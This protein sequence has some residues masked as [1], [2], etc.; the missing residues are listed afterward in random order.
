MTHNRYHV[1]EVA[2]EIVRATHSSYYYN[3]NGHIKAKEVIRKICQKY[4][5]PWDVVSKD[6]TTLLHTFAMYDCMPAI[7]A[8]VNMGADITTADN[9]GDT[10][11]HHAFNIQGALDSDSN[12]E[13]IR[14][15]LDNGFNINNVNKSG[16]TPLFML[17]DL[18][19]AYD[20]SDSEQDVVVQ[21]VEMFEACGGDIYHS[22]HQGRTFLD[23]LPTDNDEWMVLDPALD[24]WR[25]KI[26]RHRLNQEAQAVSHGAKTKGKKI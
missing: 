18:F 21:F 26:Q 5:T 19:K 20:V 3:P 11:L 6:G 13:V 23:V 25:V 4:D 17:A 12:F 8:L 16:Q 9:F 1:E 2:Y 7:T 10:I 24:P 14:W 22:D 15:A